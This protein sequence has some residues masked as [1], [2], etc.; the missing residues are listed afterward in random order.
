MTTQPP[1]PAVTRRQWDARWRVHFAEL[2]ALRPDLKPDWAQRNALRSTK[3][4]LGPRPPGA[5]GLAVK[6]AVDYLKGG[7][8]MD[9]SK[10]TWKTI[11]PILSAAAMLGVYAA[12]KSILDATDT[13]DE[14]LNIG[15]PA[16]VVPV[17]LGIGAGARNWLKHHAQAAK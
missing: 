7:G 10:T 2:R 9:W 13:A 1:R 12:A 16:I 4:E 5:A 3:V 11:R 15:V 6:L 8:K 17:L 14:L